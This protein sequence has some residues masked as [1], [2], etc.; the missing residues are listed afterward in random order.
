MTDGTLYQGFVFKYHLDS[1]GRLSGMMITDPKRYKRQELL[2]DREQG[3]ARGTDSY[4]SK[5]PSRQMY[6]L[7]D[8]IINININYAAATTPKSVADFVRE[9]ADR[10]LPTL[11]VTITSPPKE[12]S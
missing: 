1:T 12:D 9:V 3:K 8:K 2:K 6:L 4:W 10:S 7:A 5:I 11:S